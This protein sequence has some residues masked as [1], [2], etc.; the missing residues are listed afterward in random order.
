MATAEHNLSQYNIHQLPDAAHMRIG[1]VVSEW[2]DD[3]TTPLLDGAKTVLL[4]KGLK[5]ENL[6]VHHVPGSYELPTGAAFLLEYCELD[7]VITL[8]SV[9]RGETPHF[10][11]VCQAVAQGVKDVALGYMKPVIFGVL[12]DDNRQQSIDRS[13]GKH[14]N[15]G[16]EAAVTCLK[17]V[18]LQQKL[19]PQGQPFNP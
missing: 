18:A 17:M 7:A 10:D 5:K 12:T 14:G 4:Q 3:I 2:N 19:A 13:G 1:I 11:F 16:I 9:I 6:V 15:K 8:G